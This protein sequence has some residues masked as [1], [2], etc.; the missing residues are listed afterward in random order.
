MKRKASAASIRAG[1][2]LYYVSDRAV[3]VGGQP[4]VGRLQI[5]SDNVPFAPRPG[6]VLTQVPRAVA[7]RMVENSPGFLSH[8]RRAALA[9]VRRYGRLLERLKALHART[10]QDLSLTLRRFADLSEA[11][12]IVRR[13]A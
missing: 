2:T 12:P 9:S 1:Q 6:E 11:G 7:V 13:V 8:S 3:F 10:A 4:E 5:V